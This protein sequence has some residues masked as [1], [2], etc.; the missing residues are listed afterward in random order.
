MFRFCRFR[1][2]WRGLSSHFYQYPANQGRSSFRLEQSIVEN[3][4]TVGVAAYHADVTLQQVT[5]RGN[6]EAGLWLYDGYG[7]VGSSVIEQNGTGAS[8]RSG[9][10]VHYNSYVQFYYMIPFVP[11]VNRVARNAHHEVYLASS[12]DGAWLGY[13]S[14][15]PMG[16]FHLGDYNAIFDDGPQAGDER[17]IYNGTSTNV[18]ARCN[19]W[20]GA[21]ADKF[22]GTVDRAYPLSYDPTGSSGAYEGA[23]RRGW[24]RTRHPRWRRRG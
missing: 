13:C 15:G 2:G 12:A 16:S 19:Y 23:C 11:A 17:L 7:T 6:G 14:S 9:I 24:L 20:A 10:E 22:Y 5:V 4:Q 18:V 1:N 3:N 21:G 8:Y